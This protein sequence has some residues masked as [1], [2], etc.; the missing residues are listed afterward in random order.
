MDN[1]LILQSNL[2]FDFKAE[3]D[4]KFDDYGEDIVFDVGGFNLELR[5]IKRPILSVL[6]KDRLYELRQ[7]VQE[8]GTRFSRK[9]DDGNVVF[10][11]ED[12]EGVDVWKVGVL[13]SLVNLDDVVVAWGLYVI[14]KLLLWY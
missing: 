12:L 9:T 1:Y 6:Y 2:F 8:L 11:F 5:I 7:D 14:F 4:L 3:K 10:I 13:A